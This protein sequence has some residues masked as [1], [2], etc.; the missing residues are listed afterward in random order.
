MHLCS[1]KFQ[2]S[3]NN[4][5]EY[6]ED[7]SAARYFFAKLKRCE[8][9][10]SFKFNQFKTLSSFV[11]T[12]KFFVAKKP[13]LLLQFLNQKNP[14]ARPPVKLRLNLFQTK[15]IKHKFFL[16]INLQRVVAL[17]F[18]WQSRRITTVMSFETDMLF[19]FEF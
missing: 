5:S 17:V 18:L 12:F 16:D 6:K 2:A 4:F 1:Y 13:I 11:S 14:V 10:Y 9:F 15:M 3:E 7:N 19:N 8:Y